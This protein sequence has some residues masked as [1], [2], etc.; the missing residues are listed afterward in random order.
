MENKNV[1]YM[2]I[3]ISILIIIIIFL[4]QNTLTE[5]VDSSC[6]LAHGGEYCPMYDTINQQT[7]LALGIVG[8]LIV[9]G[10]VLIFSKPQIQTIVK[11]RTIEKKPEKK[12]VNVSDLKNEE[13]RVFELIKENKA[14]FQA[15]LIEKTGF[16]KAK[17]TR[18][19]DR[20]EG[21]GFVERKRRGMTNV[22]VLKE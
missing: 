6:T 12:V 5:F 10:L 18:I 21:R 14:I 7:Y 9:V 20:L 15:D 22:V 4:F 16:G 3:G 13:K 2:L 8:I 11:T 17:M 19:L 1:G